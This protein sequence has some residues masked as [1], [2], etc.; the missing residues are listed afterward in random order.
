M[1]LL[2]SFTWPD[3]FF[4]RYRRSGE[5]PLAIATYIHLCKFV[6]T[7]IDCTDLGLSKKNCPSEIFYPRTKF[8]SD[9]V[10]SFCPTLKIFVRLA[11]SCMPD[12]SSALH[13]YPTA[14]IVAH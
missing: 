14:C 1:P 6:Y 3:R 2:L 11:K 12:F 4:F 8:F 5:L 7:Y 13:V 10:E 9:C